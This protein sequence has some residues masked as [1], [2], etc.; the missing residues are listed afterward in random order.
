MRAVRGKDTKPEM[1]VRRALHRLG[2]RFRLQQRDLPGRP[3]IVLPRHRLAVFVHGCF[4]HHHSACPKATMPK[5]RVDFWSSKLEANQARDRRV[6]SDL[7]EAG[8]RV[9]TV[10]ECETRNAEVLT[11]RLIDDL[12]KLGIIDPHGT[13]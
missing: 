8:W 2:L 11:K 6:A 7:V 13:T 5:T 1:A 4:W 12:A 10:W 9:L 3:D